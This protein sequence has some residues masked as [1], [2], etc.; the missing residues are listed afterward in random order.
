ML[1]AMAGGRK[2]MGLLAP[3]MSAARC[4]PITS[5]C[6]VGCQRRVEVMG[7]LVAV[8]KAALAKC[9]AS[10]GGGV[11]GREICGMAVG[12]VS[13]T[14]PWQISQCVQALPCWAWSMSAQGALSK[15]CC[16]SCGW[17]SG[18]AG[19]AGVSAATVVAAVVIACACCAAW[20][21][22]ALL[23]TVCITMFAPSAPRTSVVSMR[24][25]KK[26]RRIFTS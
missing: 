7:G 22:A 21:G 3:R 1:G 18:C 26:K 8:A 13:A 2:G 20:S 19:A 14:A 10:V 6:T 4:Q 24:K 12:H 5:W 16:W 25:M 11:L 9:C 23:A 17:W 15:A